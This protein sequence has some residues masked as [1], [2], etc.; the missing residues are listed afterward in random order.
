MSLFNKIKGLLS[1]NEKSVEMAIDMA[2]DLVQ[3]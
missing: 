2:A 3:S 1:K